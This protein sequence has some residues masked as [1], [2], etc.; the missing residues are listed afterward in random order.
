M[1]I[2]KVCTGRNDKKKMKTKTANIVAV[3]FLLKVWEEFLPKLSSSPYEENYNRTGLIHIV[4]TFI[5]RHGQ[6]SND[7]P[8]EEYHQN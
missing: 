8:I 2:L 6:G 4:H 3:F 1:S 7:V 5:L